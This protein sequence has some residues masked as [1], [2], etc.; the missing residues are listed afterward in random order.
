MVKIGKS[1]EPTPSD[2]SGNKDSSWQKLT[3]ALVDGN[4]DNWFSALRPRPISETYPLQTKETYADLLSYAVKNDV[5]LVEQ[6]RVD[7]SDYSEPLEIPKTRLGQAVMDFL[8]QRVISME[9]R[10]IKPLTH[11][12]GEK[13]Q[14]RTRLEGQWGTDSSTPFLQAF[15]VRADASG[16]ETGFWF[17]NLLA[18]P[19][20]LEDFNYFEAHG[21]DGTVDIHTV[22]E[23]IIAA[24]GWTIGQLS[25]KVHIPL[26]IKQLA[27]MSETPFPSSQLMQMSRDIAFPEVPE[28]SRPRPFFSHLK[29]EFVQSFSRFSSQDKGDGSNA[30]EGTIF[31]EVVQFGWRFDLEALDHLDVVMPVAVDGC[32]YAMNSVEDGYENYRD[33]DYAA[34]WD[35]V[36]ANP[37]A[38]L[39]D[40]E[41]RGSRLRAP[42]FIPSTRLGD[43]LYQTRAIYSEAL[44]LRRLGQQ[45][46]A[47]ERFNLA[48]GDG[49]GPFLVHAINTY[50]YS[51][52]LPGLQENPEIITEIELLASQAVS[53]EMHGQ[54]TNALSNLGIGYFLVGD[55][56]SAERTLK[57]AL[58]REDKFSEDE[59]NYVLALVAEA[60]GEAV[61]ARKYL[62]RCEAAGGYKAPDWLSAGTRAKSGK[63]PS[64]NLNSKAAFCIACG[65]K[66]PTDEAKFCA[67]CGQKRSG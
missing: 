22:P 65:A 64:N 59:A 66:F 51:H 31:P 63:V 60:Q 4:A 67:D 37:L 46:Q 38:R 16:K 10:T 29:H 40:Y 20:A 45:N 26:F 11:E 17:V 9:F 39:A 19:I 25:T 47:I 43:I 41:S 48:I 50:L 6:L 12:T 33:L 34:P 28:E 3:L 2:Y 27:Y 54:S 14:L 58:N 44:D 42:Q 55:L 18:S 8:D 36:L 13:L 61:D 52:L 56:D 57:L 30:Y 15:E 53:M 5:A 23:S 32:T 49:A 1:S 21:D 62:E 24:G 35:D 7:Y